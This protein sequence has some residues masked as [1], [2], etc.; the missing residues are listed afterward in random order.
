MFFQILIKNPRLSEFFLKHFGATLITSSHH[1][2][3]LNQ[4]CCTVKIATPQFFHPNMPSLY[5]SQH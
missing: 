1:I 4:V 3:N 2:T 5:Q